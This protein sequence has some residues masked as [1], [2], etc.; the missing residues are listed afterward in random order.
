MKI[1][2]IMVLIVFGMLVAV[3]TVMGIR[4][5]E[6]QKNVNAARNYVTQRFQRRIDDITCMPLR[7]D[8][9]TTRC[10]VS[11][12]DQVIPLECQDGVCVLQRALQTP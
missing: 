4:Q 8:V 1:Q 10:D 7:L 2:L 6:H 9:P 12:A 11:T 5:N 3:L